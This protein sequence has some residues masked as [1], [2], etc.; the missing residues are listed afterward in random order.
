MAKALQLHQAVGL[1]LWR[2]LTDRQA[3]SGRENLAPQID[4]HDAHS[5]TRLLGHLQQAGVAKVGPRALRGQVVIDDE[6]Q[7]VSPIV[8]SFC[9]GQNA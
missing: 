6:A 3:P 8:L 9:V 4:G 2:T 1:A 7:E 5:G